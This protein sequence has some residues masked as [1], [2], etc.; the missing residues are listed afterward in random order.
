MD[1]VWFVAALW[2]LL[3]L[4]AVLAANWPRVS[5]ALSEIVAGTIGKDRFLI[6]RPHTLTFGFLTPFYFATL[7]KSV[8]DRTLATPMHV[9]EGVL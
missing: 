5:T 3:A 1:Q 6:R 2:L 4:V 8:A 7:D 9:A